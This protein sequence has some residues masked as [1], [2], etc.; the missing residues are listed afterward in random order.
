MNEPT[1]LALPDI[2]SATLP[3][4]YARATEALTECSR[5]DEC[6]NWADKAA[7]IASYAKQA[8]DP[9]L[10][11]LATRIQA[12]AVRRCGELLEQFR[13]PGTRTDKPSGD[14]PTRLQ[15][16]REVAAAAG[17]SK[18]QEV[19][20]V[21][22]ANV[23]AEEFEAAIESETPPTV[24]ALA[25]RGTEKRP[26]PPPPVGVEEATKLTGLL[27]QLTLFGEQY[28]PTYVAMG[29]FPHERPM[30]LRQIASVERW[31]HEFQRVLEG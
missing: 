17:M 8:D 12:R 9:T 25:E 26:K 16:Q 11:K 27:R 19:Q 13:A 20:A 15:T 6:I 4:L 2:A 1:A 24:T 21:R 3:T 28:H 23:P 31:L 22:V 7:A 29:L 30:L 10:H 5:I 14:A 18:D